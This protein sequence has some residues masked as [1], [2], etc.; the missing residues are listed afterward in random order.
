MSINLICNKCHKTYP[1]KTKQCEKC[2]ENLSHANYKVRVKDKTTGKWKSKT[3]PTLSLAR[4]FETKFKTEDIIKEQAPSLVPLKDSLT[5]SEIWSAY[6]AWAKLNK[7]SWHD[8]EI[9]WNKHIGPYLPVKVSQ[10]TAKDHMLPI[11]SK[12]A[13]KGYAQATIKQVFVLTKRVI[14]WSIKNGLLGHSLNPI[15]DMENP[16][17]EDNR[18]ENVL[19]R[20]GLKSLY[21]VLDAW[22]NERAVLVVR[23]ALYTGKRKGEILNL[24]WSDI[25]FDTRHYTLQRTK[26]GTRQS[27][28]LNNKAWEVIQKAKEI[29]KG[30]F[31]FPSNKGNHYK[32]PFNSTWKRIRVKAGLQGFRFHDLRHTYASYL[33]SS[34]KVDIYTLKELLGH[35]DIKMTQRYAHLINGALRKAANVADEV[36]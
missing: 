21:A 13:E 10:I 20:D 27:L 33:A 18:I 12:M 4:Q 29:K 15:G 24:K 28:P 25:N 34:G 22:E 1:I 36:F 19:D 35:S 31:V 30:P 23:F 11:M 14:N 17:M 8:D 9:R 26:G 7:K 5:V 2:G 32:E 3:V 16:K 6:I